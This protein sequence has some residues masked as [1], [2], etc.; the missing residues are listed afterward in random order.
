VRL[1]ALTMRSRPR[2]L[3]GEA[4]MHF[5]A[6]RPPLPGRRQAQ[7]ACPESPGVNTLS[8]RS[9]KSGAVQGAPALHVEL[10]VTNLTIDH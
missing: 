8:N 6:P 4:A 2:R 9:T 7:S 3:R 1:P 10:D 5:G